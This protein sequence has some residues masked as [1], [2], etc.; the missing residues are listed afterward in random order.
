MT[1]FPACCT[2]SQSSEPAALHCTEAPCKRRL[3]QLPLL[4][5]VTACCFLCWSR[6]LRCA[7]L[8]QPLLPSLSCPLLQAG[9]WEPPGC[10]VPI[11]SSGSTPG[12][13][14]AACCPGNWDVRAGAWH[15]LC[16]AEALAGTQGPGAGSPWSR[17][18]RLFLPE[19]SCSCQSTKPT[20]KVRPQFQ[21]HRT[22]SL[23]RCG[24]WSLH[25]AWALSHLLPR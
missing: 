17:R 1:P 11:G 20:S 4:L 6:D 15:Q 19:L 24:L 25:A 3:R 22:L 7:A 8:K 14:P 10:P 18:P 16:G 21:P 13:G 12:P 2:H 5:S 9:L 23:P